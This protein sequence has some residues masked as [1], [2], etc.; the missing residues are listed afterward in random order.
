MILHFH[1]GDVTFFDDDRDYFRKRFLK[2]EQMLGFDSGDPDSIEIRVHIEKSKQ[3][4]GNR[5]KATANLT[6]PRGKFHA[7]TSTENIKKC[8]D[9]LKAKLRSQIE[10]FHG[11]RK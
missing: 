11:K 9:E 7:E 5:F 2:L 1:T 10:A 8:A 6:C 4:S 3:S